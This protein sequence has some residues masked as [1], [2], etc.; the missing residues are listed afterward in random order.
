[1]TEDFKKFHPDK[2]FVMHRKFID[3]FIKFVPYATENIKNPDCAK[4]LKFLNLVLKNLQEKDEPKCED[5]TG[6]VYLNKLQLKKTNFQLII[7]FFIFSI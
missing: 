4:K 6:I 3:F 7:F 2:L 5:L 1:M